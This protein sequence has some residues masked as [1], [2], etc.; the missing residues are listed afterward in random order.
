MCRSPVDSDSMD[1][2]GGTKLPK[3][4]PF[5]REESDLR[6]LVGEFKKNSLVGK[7]DIFLLGGVWCVVWKNGLVSGLDGRV[8]I[9]DTNGFLRMQTSSWV[10]LEF[11]DRSYLQRKLVQYHKPTLP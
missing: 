2:V 7:L 3:S 5:F 6:A 10:R 9:P 1:S 8:A 4:E 11:E